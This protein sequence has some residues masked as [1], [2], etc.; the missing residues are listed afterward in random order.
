MFGKKDSGRV[1]N[2][3]LSKKQRKTIGWALIVFA[4]ALAV[5]FMFTID[6]LLNFAIAGWLASLGYDYATVLIASYTI[7][8]LTLA[9]AGIYILPEKDY[10][11]EKQVK[12]KAKSTW[13]KLTK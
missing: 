8:P 5:P 1:L 3:F 6:D 10:K 4:I 9:V 2:G 11:A 12:R 7:L 13:K